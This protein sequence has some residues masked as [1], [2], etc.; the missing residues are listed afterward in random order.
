MQNRRWSKIQLE[1][2]FMLPQDL[3]AAARLLMNVVT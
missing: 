2:D 1:Q 3:N